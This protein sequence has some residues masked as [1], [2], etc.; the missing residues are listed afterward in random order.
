[1]KKW[2]LVCSLIALSL[3]SCLPIAG[4]VYKHV[5]TTKRWEALHSHIL[6]LKVMKNQA[7]LI[8]K[9]NEILKQQ[10]ENIQSQK[11]LQASKSIR[12]LGKEQDL[13][14]SLKENSLIS[15]SKE[16]SCRKQIFLSAN[17]QVVWSFGQVSE[18]LVSL[19]LENPIEA[20]NDN[21]EEL[22][23]LLD[24]TNPCAPL[25]FFTHW[26]MTK[27]TTPLNNQVWSIN[28]EAISRWL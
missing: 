9:K 27:L 24:A 11:F 13:L 20:D 23:Y 18:D 1:M 8:R 22:F 10:H 6:T 2:S 26:E 17:N 25:A 3:V 15:Q 5:Q 19:H 7:D 12:L 21:L 14:A 28:A 4:I 16:V